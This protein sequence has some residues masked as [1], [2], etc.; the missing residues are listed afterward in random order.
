MFGDAHG[1]FGGQRLDGSAH[2]PARQTLLKIVIGQ[3][4]VIVEGGGLLSGQRGVDQRHGRPH[5]IRRA[6]GGTEVELI[7]EGVE[8]EAVVEID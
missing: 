8:R 4:L 6:V 1:V 7:G 3:E 2:L 5:A